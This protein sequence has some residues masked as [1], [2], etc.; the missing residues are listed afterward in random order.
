MSLVAKIPRQHIFVQGL[1][2]LCR[3]THDS[4]KVHRMSLV[5]KIP[6]QHPFVQGLCKLCSYP[7]LG[8]RTVKVAAE[9][10]AH[11]PLLA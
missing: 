6:R 8:H 9:L 5:A 2:K 3:V 1:C 11:L 7:A 4:I 10:A